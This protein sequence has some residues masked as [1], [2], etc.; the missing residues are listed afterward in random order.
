M[1]RLTS[2]L[3]ALVALV[4]MA[5]VGDLE[6]STAVA[7]GVDPVAVTRFIDS[8]MAVPST[9]IHHVM[10]VRHGK[11]IA[12]AHPAPYRAQDAHTLYSASKTFTA[13]AVGIAIDENRLRLTDRVASLVPDKM[14]ATISPRLA[15]MTVRDLLTMAS[16]IE[17]DWVM[18][19]SST[20]WARD[21]LAKVPNCDPGSTLQY[22]SMCTFMLSAIVQ[23]VTGMTLLDYLKLH[24]FDPM[25]ITQV[26][27]EQSPDGINTGGWGLRLQAESLAKAGILMLNRGQ[28][29]GKQLVPAQ[30]IDEMVTPHINYS[31]VKPTDAPTDGNQGY[32]YQV[33]RCKDPRAYRADGAFA[34]Y[35]VCIPDVDM[36]IV[37]NSMGHR[38]H[39]ELA[40]IWNQLMPGVDNVT[41][42]TDKAQKKLELT[43]SRAA[44]PVVKGKKNGKL[45][46]HIMLE[47]NN[48]GLGMIWFDQQG[49]TIN[50]RQGDTIS[51]G[52]SS[53]SYNNLKDLPP[54][55]ISARDRFK[56]LE[57]NFVA[58][59]NYA[60]T[61]PGVLTVRLE[62]VNWISATTIVLDFNA[63]TAT[64]TDSWAPTQPEV[65]NIR[66]TAYSK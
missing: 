12:E 39:D 7:Q 1:K 6:R 66:L 65:V 36:V 26:D 50:M 20:D 61:A 32:G 14:P 64:I 18:R 42:N 37:I 54:Y 63:N 38:G 2:L 51:L 24:V 58:A 62:Y 17:P 31:D 46:M 44:L 16:G 13:M 5:Q 53:W 29:Q 3:V 25:H 21:W 28:W 49:S 23:R 52:Y 56:G 30:W 47:K 43:C 48:H 27:W 4:A 35:I 34:Q 59:G 15:Q 57:R 19:N 41:S 22:D 8:L 33:W 11:V 55:S 10:V 60:W 40:C 45:P 9:D